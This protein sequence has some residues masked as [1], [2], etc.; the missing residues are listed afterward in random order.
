MNCVTSFTSSNWE[1]ASLFCV[2]FLT[3]IHD[4]SK[5]FVLMSALLCLTAERSLVKLSQSD[6]LALELPSEEARSS[7][8]ISPPALSA[9]GRRFALVCR[10]WVNGSNQ[11]KKLSSTNSLRA[12]NISAA[13]FPDMFYF[14]HLLSSDYITSLKVQ[15]VS[16]CS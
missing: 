10:R 16:V 13:P 1:T 3:R 4:F 12:L 8:N 2:G 14:L 5:T 15:I 6:S 11:A 9:L 7:Y